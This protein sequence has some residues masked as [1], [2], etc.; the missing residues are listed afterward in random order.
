MSRSKN[1]AAVMSMEATQMTTPLKVKALKELAT[2]V[3]ARINCYNRDTGMEYI[4]G[5]KDGANIVMEYDLYDMLDS[6]EA[7]YGSH[8][9]YAEARAR[10]NYA[11]GEDE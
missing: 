6:V 3:G 8:P 7:Y 4:L 10:F 9:S 2:S 1:P 11:T 5:D